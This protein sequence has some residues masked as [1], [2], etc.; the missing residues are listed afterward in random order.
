MNTFEW[1]GP[2]YA[3]VPQVGKRADHVEYLVDAVLRQLS[4]IAFKTDNIVSVRY[5]SRGELFNLTKNTEDGDL[6][7]IAGKLL[8]ALERDSGRGHPE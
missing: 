6:R 2:E 7:F 3:P 1:H 4:D 5:G 8:D